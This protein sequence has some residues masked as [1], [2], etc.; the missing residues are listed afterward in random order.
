MMQISQS[1]HVELDWLLELK[2]RL[3]FMKIEDIK[4]DVWY[5]SSLTAPIVF[6]GPIDPSK[7]LVYHVHGMMD[8]TFYV[9][10]AEAESFVQQALT[11]DEIRSYGAFS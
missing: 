4:H 5:W 9:S 3:L 10:P 11:D 8:R 7:S 1:F 6:D 2:V